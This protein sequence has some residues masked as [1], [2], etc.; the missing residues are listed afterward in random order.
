[1]TEWEKYD[2][3]WDMKLSYSALSKFT[4]CPERFKRERMLG[5]GPGWEYSQASA[6][7][8]IIHKFMEIL[9]DHK[10]KTDNWMLPHNAEALMDSLWTSGFP[11][12]EDDAT[13]ILQATTWLP[14]FLE[15]SKEDSLLLIPQIYDEIIPILEPIGEPEMHLEIDLPVPGQEIKKL[16]GVVD[17]M[18]APNFIIDWKTRTSGM[19]QRWLDTD[20][21]ATVYTALSGL[22]KATVQFVQ[23]I[24]LK[25]GK[26]R[27]EVAT[28]QRDQRHVDWLL[29]DMIPPIIEQIEDDI[30]GPTPG[31]WCDN[32]PVKCGAYPDLG[33]RI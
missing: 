24:F 30:M 26:P 31:W 28:T 18:A 10:I 19:N 3:L 1:M 15:K 7:G 5:L 8:T 33:S 21:Q 12:A 16:H 32:C 13:N 20:L 9:I 11:I 4:E 22:P 29:H 17:C 2:I 14:E 23:F 27:I 6:R 25:K